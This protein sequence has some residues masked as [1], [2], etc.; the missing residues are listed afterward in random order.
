MC[1]FSFNKG[2][3]DYENTRKMLFS[4]AKL[5]IPLFTSKAVG[6]TTS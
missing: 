3:R 6:L 4:E 2:V 1:G 5:S